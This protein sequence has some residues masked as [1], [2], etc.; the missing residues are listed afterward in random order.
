MCQIRRKARLCILYSLYCASIVSRISRVP[1]PDN[2]RS[3]IGSI[4]SMTLRYLR[5]CQCYICTYRVSWSVDIILCAAYRTEHPSV[6]NLVYEKRLSVLHAHNSQAVLIEFYLLICRMRHARSAHKTC[7][8][9]S[10]VPSVGAGPSQ[11]ASTPTPAL[12]VPQSAKSSGLSGGVIA[13]IIVGALAGLIIAV[14]LAWFV[15]KRSRGRSRAQTYGI[16]KGSDINDVENDGFS[17][18]GLP[19]SYQQ[20]DKAANPRLNDLQSTQSP[21]TVDQVSQ[22]SRVSQESLCLLQSFPEV[23]PRFKSQQN[24][25]LGLPEHMRIIQWLHIGMSYQDQQH[26]YYIYSSSDLKHHPLFKTV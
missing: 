21:A 15:L 3:M 6:V 12:P 5:Y 23:S 8:H 26:T 19:N 22:Y 14:A 13:G 9:Y 2:L 10:H 11:N 4:S 1:W 16:P 20:F 25:E 24:W 7:F 18:K 17:Q